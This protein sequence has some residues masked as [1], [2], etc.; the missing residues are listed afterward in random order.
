MSPDVDIETPSLQA[1]VHLRRD[2]AGAVDGCEPAAA[3][4]TGPWRVAAVREDHLLLAPIALPA[5]AARELPA[6]RALRLVWAGR[7]GRYEAPVE[8]LGV[9]SVPVAGLR[10]R[11]RAAPVLIQRRR[12]ARAPM[13]CALAVVPV[14]DGLARVAGGWLVDLGE[15]G[16]RAR[17]DCG[18][19]LVLGTAVQVHLTLGDAPVVVTGRVTR[20]ATPG[21]G[22]P[23]S[24]DAAREVVIAFDDHDDAAAHGTLLRRA[25]LGQHIRARRGTP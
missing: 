14:V 11:L 17:V 24:R 22:D 23:G 8:V 2:D 1:L 21:S 4:V 18:D 13:D 16:V 9:G 15:G 19:S 12:Y 25:V 3:D 10:V 7:R 5:L 6:G 20:L